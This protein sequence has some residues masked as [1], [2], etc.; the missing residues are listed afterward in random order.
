[1]IGEGRR[2][3]FRG[4]GP[5]SNPIQYGDRSMRTVSDIMQTDVIAVRQGT[6]VRELIQILDEEGI[7]G[8]PV[9]DSGSKVLGV[10]SRTDV[11][12]L[13]ARAPEVPLGE[14][15]WEGIS[16]MPDEDDDDP[17]SYF[18]A[19]ESSVMLVPGSGSFEGL[20]FE[21]TT[22]DEIMT[23][24]AFSVDPGMAIW[25]LAEFLV[26]GRIH[27]ALVVEDGRLVGIVTAF[28]LLRVM[29]GDASD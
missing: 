27:R 21:E 20:P 1:M 8:L 11:V 19:P 13:A 24:V 22:V 6:S 14:A 29:A 17:E 4:S 26:N 10:V 7:S 28:D 3:W 5:T 12:R 23:P 2:S 25:E 16:R 18:V 9:L 15:F